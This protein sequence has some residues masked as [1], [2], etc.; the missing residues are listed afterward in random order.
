MRL[1]EVF[2]IK[3]AGLSYEEAIELDDI[4]PAEV[5][6]ELKKHDASWDDFVKDVGNKPKYTG[7]EVLGWLGY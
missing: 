1:T 2:V 5:K 4:T 6:A 7:E 3:E